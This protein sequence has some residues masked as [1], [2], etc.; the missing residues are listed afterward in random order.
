M[1]TVGLRSK[2]FIDQHDYH[3]M[4]QGKVQVTQ[5]NDMYINLYFPVEQ[6]IKVDAI[7]FRQIYEDERKQF[8]K[9]IAN[10]RSNGYH[11]DSIKTINS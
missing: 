2:Q 4:E 5:D 3:K 1:S 7:L 11:F 9:Q 8:E 10:K 6:Q